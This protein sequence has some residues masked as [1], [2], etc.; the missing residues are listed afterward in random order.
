MNQWIQGG[1]G[2]VQH[3]DL[4]I[5]EQ[6]TSDGDALTFAGRDG[7]TTLTDGSFQTVRQTLEEVFESGGR[8]G[9]RNRLRPRRRLGVQ[10][11]FS[12]RG[13]EDERV[14]VDQRDVSPKVGQGDV[15]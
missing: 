4:R 15:P 8:R 14:L 1:G 3:K 9:P 6:C 5:H 13:V 11:V 2:L 7:E 10:N 12:D